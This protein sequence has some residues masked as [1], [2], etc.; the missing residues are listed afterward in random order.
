MGTNLLAATP[1]ILDCIFSTYCRFV[2]VVLV[3][4][5]EF[6][7]FLNDGLFLDTYFR[8]LDYFLNIMERLDL[9]YF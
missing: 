2:P 5:I 3:H 6:P 8:L 9:G 7:I 1:R 4:V